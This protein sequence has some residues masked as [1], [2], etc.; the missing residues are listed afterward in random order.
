MPYIPQEERDAIDNFEMLPATPGQLNY[1]LTVT[2]LDY[3]ESN[4]AGYT[5]FNDAIGALEA[6]KLELY[7]RHVAPYEDGK[8]EKNGDV[9]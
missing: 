7:R 6:C 4:G 8:I 5:A 9:G 1:L 2:V 3:I